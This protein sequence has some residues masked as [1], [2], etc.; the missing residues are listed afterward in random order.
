MSF[1]DKEDLYRFI[2]SNGPIREG[3]FVKFLNTSINEIVEGEIIKSTYV[4]ENKK[5][6]V[7]IIKDSDKNILKIAKAATVYN[8]LL[9]H[10]PGEASKKENNENTF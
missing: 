2:N 5:Y 10:N 8:N 6:H 3:C 1:I 7:F 4:T 9:L